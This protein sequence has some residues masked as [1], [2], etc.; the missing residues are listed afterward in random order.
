MGTICLNFDRLDK[1]SRYSSL[2]SPSSESSRVAMMIIVRWYVAHKV[3]IKNCPVASN[4]VHY[5]VGLTLQHSH[6]VKND[7]VFEDVLDNC[8]V[9]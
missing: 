3:I 9:V 7:L 4:F 6:T 2:D 8:N 5:Q 1:N